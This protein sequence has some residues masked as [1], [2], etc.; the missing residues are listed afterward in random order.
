MDISSNTRDGRVRLTGGRSSGTR[1]Q[2]P[3]ADIQKFTF[4]GSH[5]LARDAVLIVAWARLISGRG[6]IFIIEIG[7]HLLAVSRIP[8]SCI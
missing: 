8:Y 4:Q 1:V 7:G 3:V 6:P 2:A 5:V